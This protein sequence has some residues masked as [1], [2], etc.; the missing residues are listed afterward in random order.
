[1]KISK[2]EDIMNKLQN[3]MKDV[4][5][6]TRVCES[7]IRKIVFKF[8]IK[9]GYGLFYKEPE[10]YY[11]IGEVQYGILDETIFPK[12]LGSIVD[13]FIKNNLLLKTST[14]GVADYPRNWEYPVWIFEETM[15]TIKGLHKNFNSYCQKE[16]FKQIYC[17]K[18]YYKQMER[19]LIH[20]DQKGIDLNESKLKFF[21]ERGKNLPFF[22]S[23]FDEYEKRIP[24][25][26]QKKLAPIWIYKLRVPGLPI[27]DFERKGKYSEH[28]LSLKKILSYC[29][30]SSYGNA[31]RMRKIN[32]LS[33]WYCGY[34][35]VDL[36]EKEFLDNI[37]EIIQLSHIF[38]GLYDQRIFCDK[39]KKLEK[40]QL[41]Q[42]QEVEEFKVFLK[43][44]TQFY[45]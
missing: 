19:V 11:D 34:I 35:D 18:E 3:E 29:C 10:D 8:A 9:F 22:E 4:F 16:Y 45:K 44:N 39:F 21:L 23:I 24:E 13:V 42:L 17:Q 28:V 32:E 12:L 27:A 20:L 1:M 15:N 36:S 37:K 6:G 41:P 5:M 31:W 40:T 43:K 33:E 14:I 30:D 2:G 38:N 26:Y 7:E 25:R